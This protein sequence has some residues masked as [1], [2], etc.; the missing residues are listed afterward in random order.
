MLN[1]PERVLKEFAEQ[2]AE[3][4][5]IRNYENGNSKDERRKATKHERE[6]IKTIIYGGLLAIKSNGDIQSVTDTCEYIA[7]LQLPEM[8]GYDT[9]YIPIKEWCKDNIK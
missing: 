1:I 5:V 6:T 4:I 3:T 9:I 2:Q 8:N 7:K